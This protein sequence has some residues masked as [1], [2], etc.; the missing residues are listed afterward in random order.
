[1]RILVMNGPNLDMLGKREPEIYG[2][3]SLDDINN[4]I[5]DSFKG[6]DVSFEFFQSNSEG[7]IINRIHSLDCSDIEAV[8]YNPGAHTH[9][10]Y[11]I[12]DAISSV[13]VPFIEVHLSD[14]KS[15][16]SFRHKSVILPACEAQF[17]GEGKDSYIKAIKV[18]LNNEG[19]VF[20]K[21]HIKTNDEIIALKNAQ[22][23]ADRAFLKVLPH[24]HIGMKEIE[25]KSLLE[26]N[27]LEEGAESFSF[28]TLV[29]CGSNASN[30]H[31]E[32]GEHTIEEG[33][34]IVIDFGIVKGG[35]CSD[36][37]RTLF[38]GKPRGELMRAW[39]AT[40]DAHE[41]VASD[42]KIGMSGKECHEKAIS[43]LKEYGFGD[44]M[45]HG[46]GHGVGLEIHE[47]PTLSPRGK[48]LL[49]KNNVVTI[50][51]GVY[52]K[53]KFGVRLED[54]GVVTE[55]GFESFTNL[56]HELLVID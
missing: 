46:L 53:G 38:A 10:S 40:K 34:S 51:P 24:I 35:Y 2:N 39:M 31:A 3:L 8:V 13:E 54:C 37:T 9:Y 50:E 17:S 6:K 20:F 21:R 23:I 25:V 16:E 42:L 36:T 15:R 56:T 45:P 48:S 29:G 44:C 7:D 32:A 1:M 30:I 28:E 22:K 4:Y 49:L 5:L 27:L 43:I 18:F 47:K 12:R 33:Q 26:K 55:S 11:A 19:D 52:V 14:I 41:S